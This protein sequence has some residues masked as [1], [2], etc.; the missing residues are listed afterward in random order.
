MPTSATVT[1]SLLVTGNPASEQSGS[2]AYQFCL[3][4]LAAGH[5]IAGVFFYLDGVLTANS[6]ISPASDEVNLPFLWAELATQYQ[7]SLEVCV[8]AALRRGVVN[9]D[10]ANLLGL[11]H[12]NVQAPFI[13]S[14]L[15]QL[16]ELSASCDRLIQ[17]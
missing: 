4:A 17:F 13:L 9:Q 10:E 6:L 16:A 12:G 7:F 1:F 14:G 2:T 3:A 15:G 5:K 8:S 11:P